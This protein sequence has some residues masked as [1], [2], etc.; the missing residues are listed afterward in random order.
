MERR[1]AQA[2]DERCRVVKGLERVVLARQDDEGELD[3]NASLLEVEDRLEDGGV[4][5]AAP[6]VGLGGSEVGEVDRIEEGRD[7]GA[8]GREGVAVRDGDAG[9]LLGARG[10]GDLAPQL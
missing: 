2:R 8:G 10:G 9:E 4:L 3:V 1:S 7:L 5:E 6:A